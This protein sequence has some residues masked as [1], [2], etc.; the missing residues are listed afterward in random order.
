LPSTLNSG[1]ILKIQILNYLYLNELPKVINMLANRGS[2]VTKQ[3]GKLCYN[4]N[5]NTSTACF[6]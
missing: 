4:L 1:N 2:N 6:S 5:P 3:I